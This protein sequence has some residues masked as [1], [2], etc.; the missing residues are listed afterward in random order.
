MLNYFITPNKPNNYKKKK[1]NM[2]IQIYPLWQWLKIFNFKVKFV[3]LLYIKMWNAW[4]DLWP[5]LNDFLL[6]RV[7]KSFYRA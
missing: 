6:L 3:I 5:E 4:K 2:K 1:N 7:A